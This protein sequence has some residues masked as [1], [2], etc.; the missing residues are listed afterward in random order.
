MKV[1]TPL[2]NIRCKSKNIFL[3]KCFFTVNNEFGLCIE[4]VKDA[5]K[6][7][8]KGITEAGL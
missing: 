5:I 4:I 7:N 6:L 1:L 2:I 8:Y 3:N